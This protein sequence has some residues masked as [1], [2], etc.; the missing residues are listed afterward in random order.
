MIHVCKITKNKIKT[1]IHLTKLPFCY[2][3]MQENLLQFKF[4]LTDIKFLFYNINIVQF[5]PR[6]EINFFRH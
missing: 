6:I 5:F 3:K 4:C 1:A 2:V